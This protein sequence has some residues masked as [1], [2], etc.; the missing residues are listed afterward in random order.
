[1]RDLH[2]DFGVSLQFIL[3]RSLFFLF[4]LSPFCLHTPQVQLYTVR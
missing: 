1:M 3:P 4:P 2:T